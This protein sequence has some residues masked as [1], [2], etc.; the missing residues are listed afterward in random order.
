MTTHFIPGVI[1]S[2]P[3]LRAPHGI[4]RPH[5]VHGLGDG[6][7]LAN[8]MGADA[9][10]G[11]FGAKMRKIPFLPPIRRRKSRRDMGGLGGGFELT[12]PLASFHGLGRH[13]RQPYA[14]GVHGLLGDTEPAEGYTPSWGYFALAAAGAVIVLGGVAVVLSK[15]K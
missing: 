3:T 15:G 14:Y 11:G 1:H 13:H 5:H 8:P 6:F 10:V 9:G 12:D 7:H 2:Q 4:F